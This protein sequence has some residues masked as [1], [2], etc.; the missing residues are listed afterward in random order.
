MKK[1]IFI[2][3]FIPILL[4]SQSWVQHS[5][6]PFQ[7]V[8]HPITFSYGQF[9]FVV[10]GSNTDNVYKYDENNGNWSQLSDFPGG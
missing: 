9:G 5:I 8:H 1:I 4:F 10:A 7:G 3:N 6:F 2:L